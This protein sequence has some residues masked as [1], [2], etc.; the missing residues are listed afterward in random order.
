M[1]ISRRGR[2][3]SKSGGEKLGMQVT[4]KLYKKDNKQFGNIVDNEFKGNGA[5]ALRELITE[6]LTARR[7]KGLGRDNSLQAVKEAQ[8]EVVAGE[9]EEIKAMLR[10][11][12][13]MARGSGTGID[14]VISQNK[15]IYGVIFH[16]LRTAFNIEE[17]SQEYLARPALE[18]EGKDD[19]AITATFRESEE[20]W[21][22]E[23]HRVVES[24]RTQLSQAGV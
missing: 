18:E 7:L 14:R 4:G 5:L 16:V 23:A 13:S 10:D 11:L 19:E 1:A 20:G 15:E 12:I 3:A 8:H 2:G 21:T 9:T 17:M 6:A 24:V 22:A